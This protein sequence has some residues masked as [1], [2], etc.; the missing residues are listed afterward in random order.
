MKILMS[1]LVAMAVLA[2]IAGPASAACG[3]ADYSQ[4]DGC[5]FSDSVG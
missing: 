2:G 5:P 3:G 1:A 4:E